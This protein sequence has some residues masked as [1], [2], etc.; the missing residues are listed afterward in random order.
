MRS[1]QVILWYVNMLQRSGFSLRRPSLKRRLAPPEITGRSSAAKP[2]SSRAGRRETSSMH[3]MARCG[4]SSKS[5]VALE[6]PGYSSLALNC[7]SSGARVIGCFGV[8]VGPLS[9]AERASSTSEVRTMNSCTLSGCLTWNPELRYQS[10][11]KPELYI[12]VAVPNGEKEGTQFFLPFDVTVFGKD[13]EPLAKVLEAGDLVELTGQNAWPKAPRKPGGKWIPAAICFG[14]TRLAGAVV[15]AHE[16]S[17][18][19]GHGREGEDAAVRSEASEPVPQRKPRKPTYP[20][21]L[22]E[23]WT[24]AGQ[25]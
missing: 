18:E 19:Y 12:R 24:P 4:T 15:S 22:R 10:N 8:T 17:P 25:H 16:P 1:D 13:C 14:V 5:K 23:P 20:K 9:L 7:R 2:A 21:A 11:G 3:G 6:S